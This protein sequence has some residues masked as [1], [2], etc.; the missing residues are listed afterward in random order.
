[1]VY[2]YIY[3]FALLFTRKSLLIFWH[4]KCLFF[5]RTE[6]LFPNGSLGQSG[7]LVC[8]ILTLR[9]QYPLRHLSE[10]NRVGWWLPYVPVQHFCS[11]RPIR[12]VSTSHANTSSRAAGNGS[13]DD[14]SISV[15]VCPSLYRKWFIWALLHMTSK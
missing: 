4:Y 15:T 7:S 9:N 6:I 2:I 12:S 8:L 14:D 11:V 5:S 1:M 10:Q 13:L 3:I